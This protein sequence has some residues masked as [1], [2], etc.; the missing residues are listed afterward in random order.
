M[1][2]VLDSLLRSLKILAGDT[3]IAVTLY[4]EGCP[5]VLDEASV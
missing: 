3:Y 5:A 2:A 1:C 4:G